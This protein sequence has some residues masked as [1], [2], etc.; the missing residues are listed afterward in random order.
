MFEIKGDDDPIPEPD[1]IESRALLPIFRSYDLEATA[2]RFAAA[3]Y[4]VE[5]EELTPH[6]RTLWFRGP[7]G[8]PIGFEQRE[9]DSPFA[10]DAEAL[11]RWEAGEATPLEGASSLAGELQYLSRARRRVSD[12]ER[13]AAFYLDVAGF[14]AVGTEDDAVVFSMGDTVLL[15]L[16][17]G[18][19]R[20]PLPKDRSEVAEAFI[21]RIHGFDSYID[22][23]NSAGATWIGEQIRYSTGS[24]LAYF[25]DP[26]GMPIGVESR[27]LWGN[28]PD[29]L[30]LNGA[31]R[32]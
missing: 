13:A 10:A 17:P 30:K 2:A 32:G 23:L 25:A 8:M 28:Y 18:G 31:G 9:R 14:D 21:G 26:D 6:V 27:T 22:E 3:G 16:R 12:L 19:S 29:D 20:R 11:R 5:R 7:D 24:N 15:E 1:P 4:A